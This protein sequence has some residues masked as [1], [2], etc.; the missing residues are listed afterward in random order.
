[1]IIIFKL[2]NIIMVII[3]VKSTLSTI[4]IIKVRYMIR[5]IL[6]SWSYLFYTIFVA[7]FYAKTNHDYLIM[8]Q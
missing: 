3:K 7:I 4:F 5:S 1:M 8:C 6:F 2:I